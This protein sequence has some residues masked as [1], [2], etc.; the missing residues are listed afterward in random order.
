[1]ET[2]K[3]R[4]M[5]GATRGVPWLLETA[6]A[7]CPNFE[8]GLVAVTGCN[9]T[10]SLGETFD[11]LDALLENLKV[12]DD[13]AVMVAVHLTYPAAMFTDKG[14]TE[15]ALPRMIA[16]A[17]EDAVTNVT[18]AWTKHK[19]RVERDAAA[20]ERSEAK[21][22]GKGVKGEVQR[23]AWAVI[24]KAYLVV[25]ANNTL[26]AKARQIMYA[27]TSVHSGTDGQAT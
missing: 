5:K 24:P 21:L 19:K 13:D 17:I 16:L 10:P 25:S 20:R 26:P 2:F 27:R 22:A 15:L 6:F 4:H 23:A 8:G 18:A 12:S 1:M 7:H 9:W 11:G 14:K 3:Y